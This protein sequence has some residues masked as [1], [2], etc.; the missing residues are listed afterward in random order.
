MQNKK[1]QNTGAGHVL[2]VRDYYSEII[3]GNGWFGNSLP[4]PETGIGI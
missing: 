1:I 2:V 3:N 4:D